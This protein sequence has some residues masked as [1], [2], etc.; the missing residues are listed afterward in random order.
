[1]ESQAKKLK[2]NFCQIRIKSELFSMNLK[3][4]SEHL[5]TGLSESLKTVW[6]QKLL[7]FVKHIERKIQFNELINLCYGARKQ[8]QL[9][10]NS[11]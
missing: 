10:K 3:F 9:L 11:E 6:Y 1:L 7:S 8:E 5:K 2:S 4:K